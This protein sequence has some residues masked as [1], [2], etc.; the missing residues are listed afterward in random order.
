MANASRNNPNQN[1]AGFWG[2]DINFNDLKWLIRS[3]SDSCARL[4]HG[5]G[6][7]PCV[8]QVPLQ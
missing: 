5:N 7:L 6:Y 1:L 3:E 8:I 2:L 4:Y